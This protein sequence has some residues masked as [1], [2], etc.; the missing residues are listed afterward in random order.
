MA[1]RDWKRC[2]ECEAILDY[3]HAHECPP[4]WAV[5]EDNDQIH[6]FIVHARAADEAIERWCAKAHGA[7]ERLR[8][9]H[10]ITVRV[11]REGFNEPPERHEIQGAPAM[12]FTQRVS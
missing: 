12:V 11:K 9:G 10:T 5:W 3:D 2:P 4:K 8:D 1:N 7:Q 6:I